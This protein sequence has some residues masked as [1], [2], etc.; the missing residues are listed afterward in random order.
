MELFPAFAKKRI[1][2]ARFVCRRLPKTFSLLP[3]QLIPYCQYTANA[4]LGTLL[5]GLE[6][7]RR[8]QRGFY[9]ASVGVDPDSLVTPWLVACWMALVL[10]G[11]RRAHAVLG[12]WYDLSPI[13]TFRMS[14]AWEEIEAYFLCL[15]WKRHPPFRDA[16]YRY[17]RSTRHFLF[18]TP[19]QERTCR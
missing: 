14:R 11:L 15:G 8:G 17:S 2:I 9:G 12:R 1:P 16:F 10:R 3:L 5:M 18:G 13:R 7:R 6:C 4:I 19:S